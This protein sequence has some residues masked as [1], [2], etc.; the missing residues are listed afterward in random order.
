M[1]IDKK[2]LVVNN[3][4]WFRFPIQYV[5]NS[6]IMTV[7]YIGLVTQKKNTQQK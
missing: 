1:M 7:P 2:E 4:I 5:E 6:C 3:F